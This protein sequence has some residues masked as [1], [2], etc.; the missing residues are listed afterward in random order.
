ML[1]DVVLDCILPIDNVTTH[2]WSLSA[3][4]GVL[5]GDYTF[6]MTIEDMDTGNEV[7][8]TTAGPSQTLGPHERTT[9]TFTPWNGWM[10]GHKYN[11]SYHA[12]LYQM[13][14]LQA[15]KDISMLHLL[16]TLMLQFF[17]EILQELLQSRK[18]YLILG[19]TYTQ[20]DINDWQEYLELG[21]LVHYDKVIMP[22]QDVNTAKPSDEGGKGYYE[23][24][25][26]ALPIRTH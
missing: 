7:H 13:E 19:M 2:D 14:V 24:I 20:Y 23:L 15:M 8:T 18:I 22:W 12:T 4:N 26:K 9:V 5:Q 11:I 25:G 10:D 21:W 3:T 6:H 17:R 1:S 16:K